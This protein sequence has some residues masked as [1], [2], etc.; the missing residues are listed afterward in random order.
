MSECLSARGQPPISA[1]LHGIQLKGRIQYK[2]SCE[3]LIQLNDLR[4][5]YIL[6]S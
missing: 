4:S 2:S 5:V 6:E 1:Y 3:S